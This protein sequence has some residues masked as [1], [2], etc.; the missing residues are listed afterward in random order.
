VK[1][2]SN[3]VFVEYGSDCES[4]LRDSIS[5]TNHFSFTPNPEPKFL[6]NSVFVEYRSDCESFLCDSISLTNHFSFTPNPESLIRA[7]GVEP[8]CKAR[9]RFL[10][11]YYR[12]SWVTDMWTQSHMSLIDSYY[13]GSLCTEHKVLDLKKRIQASTVILKRKMQAKI[14]RHLGAPSKSTS[15]WRSPRSSTTGYVPCCHMF[16]HGHALLT[17]DLWLAF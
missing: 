13:R 6:S 14:P 16:L 17:F 7:Q 11:S 8:F 3:S 1:F 4:F 9:N 15:N 2:L 5:L 12:G 10:C